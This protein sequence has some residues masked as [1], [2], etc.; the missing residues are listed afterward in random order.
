VVALTTRPLGLRDSSPRPGPS[1]RQM[2]R[3][4][5]ISERQVGLWRRFFG[6]ARAPS[7]QVLPSLSSTQHTH[8]SSPCGFHRSHSTEAV[9]AG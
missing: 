4:A 6:Q 3:L 7:L 2:A 9:P 8:G 1:A 5:E